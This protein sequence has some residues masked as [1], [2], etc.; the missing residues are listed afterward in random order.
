MV[1]NMRVDCLDAMGSL[2]GWCDFRL[3]EKININRIK[4]KKTNPFVNKQ[5]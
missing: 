4:E 2:C 1:K 5:Q 3:G